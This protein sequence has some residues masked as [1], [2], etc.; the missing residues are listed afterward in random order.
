MIRS[1]NFWVIEKIKPDNS[2]SICLYFIYIF[3]YVVWI[4]RKMIFISLIVFFHHLV[5]LLLF[6]INCTGVAMKIVK[7]WILDLTQCQNLA[8]VVR[9]AQAI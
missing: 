5:D 7:K 2:Y 4:E 9:I 8:Q 6:G 1:D 3:L